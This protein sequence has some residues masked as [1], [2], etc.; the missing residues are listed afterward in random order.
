MRTDPIAKHAPEHEGH[1]MEDYHDHNNI[2]DLFPGAFSTTPRVDNIDPDTAFLQ[3]K[4]QKYEDTLANGDS[5]DGK[6]LH[7]EEDTNDAVV[8]VNGHDHRGYGSKVSSDHVAHNTITDLFP[9]HFGTVP[10]GPEPDFAQ[11]GSVI[12]QKMNL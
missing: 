1:N 5:A 10:R 2:N 9:E 12:R 7:E 6:D 11:T 4:L 8:D 3:L